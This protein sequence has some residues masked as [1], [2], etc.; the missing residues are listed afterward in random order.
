MKIGVHF[1]VILKQTET[2]RHINITGA[3][4]ITK[5]YA[6]IDRI[7]PQGGRVGF[8]CGEHLKST[9][10]CPAMH[11]G[12]PQAFTRAKKALPNRCLG[13]YNSMRE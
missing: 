8:F 12:G 13:T 4:T 2:K 7:S 5:P 11:T 1:A 10:M 6:K 3:T 9:A